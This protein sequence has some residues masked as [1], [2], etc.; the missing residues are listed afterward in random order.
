MTHKLVG[1]GNTTSQEK[2]PKKKKKK[3]SPAGYHRSW[4]RSRP[5]LLF[6]NNLLTR[7]I[8]IYPCILSIGGSVCVSVL[9]CLSFCLFLAIQLYFVCV[10]VWNIVVSLLFFFSQSICLFVYLSVCLIVCL[11]LSVF[12]SRLDNFC[13]SISLSV[14]LLLKSSLDSLCFFLCIFLFK[15]SLYSVSLS[16]CRFPSSNHFSIL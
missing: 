4:S 12:K 8:T 7:T 16:V 11:S 1:D 13:L 9:F 5:S 15:S 2:R 6:S 14:C 3:K 10:L